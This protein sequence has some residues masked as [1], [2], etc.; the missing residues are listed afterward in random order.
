M[1]AVRS[2]PAAFKSKNTGSQMPKQDLLSMTPE[3][4]QSL[5][6]EKRQQ[7]IKEWLKTPAG[8]LYEIQTKDKFLEQMYQTLTQQ[9]QEHQDP[10]QLPERLAISLALQ[11][12]SV[13]QVNLNQQRESLKT[14]S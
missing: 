14:Q 13:Q 12:L 8:Q 5:S 7:L 2:I 9:M 1:Q 10:K 3:K 4:A 6:E 11:E